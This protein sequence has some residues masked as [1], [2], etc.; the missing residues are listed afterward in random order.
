[1]IPISVSDALKLLDQIP[2]WKAVSALP[3]RV[4]ELE[5]RVSELEAAAKASPAPAKI[6]EARIC[7][8]CSSEMKVVAELP[9][10]TFDFAGVKIH[11]LSC[12]GCDNKTERDYRPGKGYQ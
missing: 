9:H 4:A 8:L 2:I 5:R 12:T 10:P 11:K 6:P 7:P 3:K 1:M